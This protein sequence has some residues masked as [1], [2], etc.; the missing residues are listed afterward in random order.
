M[1]F[2]FEDQDRSPYSGNRFQPIPAHDPGGSR[3][4]GLSRFRKDETSLIGIFDLDGRN[5]GVHRLTVHE[6]QSTNCI[7]HC[8]ERTTLLRVLAA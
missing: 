1:L 7:S 8:R 6:A 4:Q 2:G 5:Y 3:H